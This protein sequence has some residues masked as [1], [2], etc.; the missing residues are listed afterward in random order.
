MSDEKK[1]NDAECKAEK[2]PYCHTAIV[3]PTTRQIHQRRAG[4]VITTTMRFCCRDCGG[5]Y[6]MGCE[7]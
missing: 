5:Y 2:C 6:Q 7:G 4:K 3:N 1:T